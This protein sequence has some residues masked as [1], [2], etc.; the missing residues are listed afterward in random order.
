VRAVEFEERHQADGVLYD[1]IEVTLHAV[2]GGSERT[3]QI[4]EADFVLPP[5]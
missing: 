3:Q 4:S 2:A 1:V 5:P